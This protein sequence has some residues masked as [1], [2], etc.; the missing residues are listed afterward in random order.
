MDGG[1]GETI[2]IKDSFQGS[3]FNIDYFTIGNA[4][5]PPGNNVY[6]DKEIN[7]I[8]N[9]DNLHN[10]S[11]LYFNLKIKDDEGKYFMV[12]TSG[13]NKNLINNGKGKALM[14]IPAGFF[15]EGNY[16]IELMVIRK[17]EAGYEVVLHEPNFSYIQILPEVREVGSWFGKEVGYIRHQFEWIKQ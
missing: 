9:Y 3:S 13:E 15:N 8:F 17:A 2:K 16:F 7:F 1:V 4:G 14:C 6:R 5:T 11:D 12:T 10:L